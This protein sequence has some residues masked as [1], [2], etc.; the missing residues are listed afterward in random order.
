MAMDEF[1][2]DDVE[3]VMSEYDIAE[4]SELDEL[5]YGPNFNHSCKFSVNEEDL[6]DSIVEMSIED[7]Q[8]SNST[9]DVSVY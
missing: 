2:L 3:T 4:R 8:N 5:S 1:S 9:L 7:F 6:R